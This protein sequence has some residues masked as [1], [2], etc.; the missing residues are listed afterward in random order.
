MK[1][2]LPLIYLGLNV[3]CALVVLFAAHRVGAVI[4]AEQRN[5]SDGVDSITFVTASAPAFLL[6]V[7]A[8]VIWTGKAVADASRRQDYRALAWLGT[9]AAVWVSAF[10]VMRVF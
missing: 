4:A 5:H 10:V 2:S 8:N 1:R 6:A 9:A 7:L 3:G